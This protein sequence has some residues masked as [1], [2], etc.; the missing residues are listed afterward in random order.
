MDYFD[1]AAATPMSET[2]LAAM[3]PFFTTEFYNPSALYLK[4]QGVK[5]A[6][7]QARADVAAVLGA[8]APEI[9]FTAGGTESDNLAIQGVMQ[10]F[11]G[12]NCVVSVIEHD[13]VLVPA[14]RYTDK[15][16][17][18][19]PDGR[20]DLV[21]L[22]KLIDNDT[23]LVSIMYA[24][25]EIG[26]VQPLSD[27]ATIIKDVRHE[28][29]AASNDTP[30][31]FHTDACQA[32]NYLQL[33]VNSLGVDLMTLN[34]GKI[35][36]PKQS[37]ILYVKTGVVLEPQVLGGGQERG[38][39]SGTENVP[40]IVG[41]AA[42]LREASGMREAEAKRLRELQQY[43]IHELSVKVPQV[44]VNGSTE[45]RL[46]NNLHIT[47]PGADNERLMM[48][49]DE[50]GIMVATGSACSASSDEPSHVLRAIGLS[51]EQAQSSLR[52]TLGRQT[53]Q[54]SLDSLLLSKLFSNNRYKNFSQSFHG[55]MFPGRDFCL[56]FSPAEKVAAA[57]FAKE[58][59]D[60]L[61]L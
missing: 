24:N 19:R 42:A 36:G 8:K 53:L 39:R 1:Y 15:T 26:T 43:L 5:R 51:D 35:Y 11:P 10:A 34:G 7:E 60:F 44:I 17:P 23:V 33:L 38:K 47:V 9:I 21:E 16:V 22:K 27:I 31:Y 57:Y 55:L 3:Q 54:A 49:L 30:L 61:L 29:L 56:I 32:A 40:A 59:G 18:V 50:R 6:V 25:N 37:G 52:I 41:F 13:A 2:V 12:K 46:P 58:H 4:A 28:R 48:E 45:Y 14:S 20:V